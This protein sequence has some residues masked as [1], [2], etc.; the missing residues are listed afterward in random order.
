MEGGGGARVGARG[1]ARAG[2]RR[3]G[4]AGVGGPFC[5]RDSAL[6]CGIGTLSCACTPFRRGGL[7]AGRR[8]ATC[9]SRRD[10]R[11][12]SRLGRRGRGCQVPL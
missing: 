11:D 7:R 4:E 10:G 2:W 3:G 6:G 8:T 9:S 12:R 5:T 1:S